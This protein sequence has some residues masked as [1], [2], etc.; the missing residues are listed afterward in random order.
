MG[1]FDPPTNTRLRIHVHV[2]D[3]GGYYDI[4]D[5]LLQNQH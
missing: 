5:G 3:K 2:A 1:A 4:V